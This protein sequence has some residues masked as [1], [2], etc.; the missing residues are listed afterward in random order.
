MTQ[1]KFNKFHHMN[2]WNK[3]E[4]ME[5]I[6]NNIKLND[7][8]FFLFCYLLEYW[9]IWRQKVFWDDDPQNQMR[10][11]KLLRKD[12]VL[13][14]IYFGNVSRHQSA[15]FGDTFIGPH[16]QCSGRAD[17]SSERYGFSKLS[18]LCPNMYSIK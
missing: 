14:G 15:W 5:F 2:E 1:I 11:R 17:F 12:I 7:D 16:T 4:S 9:Y 3:N 10:F 18:S 8:T 6:N 13:Y